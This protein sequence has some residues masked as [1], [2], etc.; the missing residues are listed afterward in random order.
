MKN[1]CINWFEKIWTKIK[2]KPRQLHHHSGLQAEKK[3]P[4]DE[5]CISDLNDKL[6]NII[7]DL[8][9]DRHAVLS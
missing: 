9:Y 7:K 1:V 3:K 4:F 2:I 5:T 6:Q 8:N